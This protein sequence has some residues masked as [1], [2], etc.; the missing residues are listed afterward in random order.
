MNRAVF[1]D[2]D[3]VINCTVPRRGEA[4]PPASVQE[5]VIAPDVE[6]GLGRLKAAGFRLVVVTNQPDVARGT[7]T[8]EAVDLIHQWLGARLPLDEFRACFHDDVDRCG[9][10]KPQP[11]MIVE[12]AREA[13][14]DLPRS[15]LIGDRWRDVEAAAECGLH[16]HF[17]RLRLS[18]KTTFRCI[19]QRAVLSR[20]DRLDFGELLV[21]SGQSSVVKPGRHRRPRAGGAMIGSYRRPRH[22]NFRF[23][24]HRRPRTGGAMI[25]SYSD[26]PLTTNHQPLTPDH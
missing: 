24:R 13:G 6:E 7:L 25:G 18:G 20:S 17:H 21:V 19:Y 3:G 5:T 26:C 15:F 10:R 9:C 1:L 4:C 14:L 12:A 22:E 2:R 16:A 11:G 8:R 23:F